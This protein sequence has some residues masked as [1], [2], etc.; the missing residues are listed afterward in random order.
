VRQEWSLIGLV[1]CAVVG[2]AVAAPLV[3]SVGLALFTGGAIT[4]SNIAIGVVISAAVSL[5]ITIVFY[6]V[7]IGLATDF[8][9]KAEV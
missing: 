9:K 6:R 7:N 1:V 3:V 4:L 8:L 5:G 2:A